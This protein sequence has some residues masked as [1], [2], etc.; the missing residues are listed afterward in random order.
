MLALLF[1]APRSELQGLHDA[2]AILWFSH[3]SE[4][5]RLGKMII[6]CHANKKIIF[7]LDSLLFHTHGQS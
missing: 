2:K 4:E 7:Q 1:L 5:K 6:S 3:V